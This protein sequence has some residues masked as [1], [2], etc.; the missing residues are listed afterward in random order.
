MIPYEGD[1]WHV[2][3]YRLKEEKEIL[4][5]G[6]MDIMAVSRCLIEWPERLGKL[7]PPHRTEVTISFTSQ[8]DTRWIEIQSF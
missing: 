3:L 6:L 5:L 7:M 1:L 8:E 4:Q 2:D